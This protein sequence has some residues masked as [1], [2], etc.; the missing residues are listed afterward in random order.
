MNQLALQLKQLKTW[1]QV[2]DSDRLIP[3]DTQ[4][5]FA[6]RMNITTISIDTSHP[7]YVALPDE[8]AQ[9]ILDAAKG[10]TG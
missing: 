9:L 2:S 3:P 7:S 10:S 4:R 6:Q 1:Y 8:I 5:M